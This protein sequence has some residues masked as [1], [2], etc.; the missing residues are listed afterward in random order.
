[1]PRTFYES[2]AEFYCK[3]INAQIIDQFTVIK[4]Y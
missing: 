3:N 1:M 4:G 2:R